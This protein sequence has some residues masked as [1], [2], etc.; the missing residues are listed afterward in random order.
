[1][2]TARLLR[3]RAGLWSDAATGCRNEL[4]ARIDAKTGDDAVIGQK[5]YLVA[6]EC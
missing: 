1:M 6:S 4:R 3:H 2:G 5:L